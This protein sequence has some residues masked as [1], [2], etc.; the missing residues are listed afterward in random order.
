M[1]IYKT[2]WFH[3]WAAR[4]GVSDQLL[5]R[6][7]IEM[8][9]GLIDANLGGNVFKKRI[10]I[11][12]RGKSTST[13]TLLAFKERECAFFI[14]G[15]AKNERD[16]VDDLEL[17]AIKT[18]ARE[19]LGYSAMELENAESAKILIKVIGDDT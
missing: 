19:L 17:K 11:H 18:Y 7:I 15:F 14:Y 2:R 13:R 4:Q 9:R 12:G 16:N 1:L 6:A 8:N 10:G 5:K 3:K